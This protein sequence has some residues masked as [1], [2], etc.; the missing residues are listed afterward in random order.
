MRKASRPSRRVMTN[1]C[2]MAVARWKQLNETE[3]QY[4]R[5][6]YFRHIRPVKSEMSLR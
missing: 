4:V 3:S 1:A 2:I 5:P 6:A